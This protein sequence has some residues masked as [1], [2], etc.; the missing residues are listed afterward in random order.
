MRQ[1]F[2]ESKEKI[3]NWLARFRPEN[4]LI[5]VPAFNAYE[6]TLD[7]LGSLQ[8][9][10]PAQTPILLI[11]D[12]SIGERFPDYFEPLSF[13]YRFAYLRKP[14]NKGFVDSVNLGF[15]LAAPRDVVVINS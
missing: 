9:N 6:D 14:V 4:P 7:C 5:V 15:E 8:N 13:K 1:P 3:R 10:T 12:A 11:D 2:E